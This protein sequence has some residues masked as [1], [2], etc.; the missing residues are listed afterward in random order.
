MNIMYKNIYLGIAFL[1][2]SAL[3]F[4][5]EAGNGKKKKADAK[6]HNYAYDQAIEKYVELDDKSIDSKRKL[7]MSY[8]YTNDLAKAEETFAEIVADNASTAEDAYMY[9]AILR[10]NEKYT[11]SDTWMTKFHALAPDDHRGTDYASH[12]GEHIQ[13]L[14]DKGQFTI[15]NLD[16]NTAEE[17]FGATYYEDMVLFASSRHTVRTIKRTWNR[18]NL[19]YLD[20]YQAHVDENAELSSPHVFR[21]GLNKRYHEGPV[22]FNKEHTTMIYTRNNYQHRSKDGTVKLQMF[23]SHLKKHGKWSRPRP[24]THNSIEYSVGHAAF[25][26]DGKWLYFASD[27]EG[28][29]GGVDLYKVSINEDDTFGEMINLGDKINTEGTEMFPDIHDKGMLFFSS[30][31]LVGLGGLDLFVAELKPDYSIGKVMNFGTPMNS[32]KDDFS[33]VLHDSLNQGYFASNR[34]G[35]KG[36]DDLYSFNMLKPFS[37]GKS[38]QGI[39]KDKNGNILAGALINLYDEAGNKVQTA[40]SNDKGEFTFSAEGDKKFTLD[41]NKEDYFEGKNKVNTFT[42]EA[43]IKTDVVLEKDPGLS[44]Y[45]LITDKKTGAPLEG[46][47]VTLTDN[48]TAKSERF[49]TPGTGDYRKALADKKLKDR[50]SYNLTLQKAGYFTKTVTYNTEFKQPG[51]Y[52]VHTNLDLSLDEEVTD[53]GELVVINPIKFDYNKFNIRPDAAVELDKI[54]EVMNKY[55]H[56]VVELGAH[57]DCRGSAAYNEKLSDRRAKASAKYI[58]GKI[59]NPERIYGKGYGENKLLNTCATCKSC[60]KEEH[61]GNRRTEFK[62]ISTGNDKLKVHN[63]STDSFEK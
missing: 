59:T 54:V 3:S 39:A 45:A 38:I 17:D 52:D 12:T 7:A 19:P 57:T 63:T 62:V 6:Y 9:A 56:M 4:S 46:V 5:Q 27:I 53:L 37:F 10:K 58:K 13:L 28:G 43:I 35:G 2:I 24:F 21:K 47:T 34:D 22:A 26:P 40:T 15:K 61:D 44:L 36:D 16:I 32:S 48:M 33:F 23:V 8:Y 18:N 41:G 1:A 60:T 29:F 31:G 50:G 55:E 20:I 30:D 49:V 25:T 42:D 11:E 51:Q 14:K